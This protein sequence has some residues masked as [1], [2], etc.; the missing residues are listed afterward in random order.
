MTVVTRQPLQ[1]LLPH[2]QRAL[3][4]FLGGLLHVSQNDGNTDFASFPGL[5]ILVKSRGYIAD[6]R[7]A[8]RDMWPAAPSKPTP[9]F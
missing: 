6:G 2:M 9:Q 8:P 1:L 5:S 3:S 7:C 4:A